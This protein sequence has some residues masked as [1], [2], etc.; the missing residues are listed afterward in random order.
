MSSPGTSIGVPLFFTP[1]P[2]ERVWGG[3]HLERLLGKPLPPGKSIG[4]SWELCDRAEAQ[5]V[6]EGGPFAGARL[7]ELLARAPEALLGPALAARKLARFPLLVKFID[8]NQDLS[9]QVHP[10]DDDVRRLGLSDRGKTEC[11]VIVHAEPGARIQRGVKPG[12]TRHTF[13]EALARGRVEEVLHYV[14]VSRG[15][16]VAIPPGMLHAIGAGIVLAE[17]QQNSD[18]TFRVYDY[19]RPG[20]DGRP[21]PL[22]LKEALEVIRFEGSAPG[23]FEEDMAPDVVGA[24]ERLGPLPAALDPAR[25]F[26]GVAYLH[27]KYFYLR[28]WVLMPGACFEGGLRR[29]AGEA[30]APRI[31]VFLHGA[32][33]LDGRAVGA[34]QTVLVPADLAARVGVVQAEGAEP[35]IFLESGPTPEA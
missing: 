12:V 29:A 16:V 3:K 1:L 7:H 30:T 33:S 10:S 24:S 34:G 8:A 2:V 25:K 21:R 22:H 18:L 11:W 15:D 31:W 35:L 19:G 26:M 32:G 13:E 6:V 20:L 27:G 9:V 28:K 4:E 14:S 17:I 23:F 5:S